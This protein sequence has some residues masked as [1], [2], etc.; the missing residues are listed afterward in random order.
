MHLY[1]WTYARYRLAAC[2]SAGCSRSAAVS[3]SNLRLEAVGYFK[4]SQPEAGAQFGAE[5]DLS[6]DGYNFVVVAPY[7]GRT[8]VGR[9][10]EQRRRIRVPARL[11]GKWFQRA[12]LDLHDHWNDADGADV[13]VATSGS[14]NTIAVALE[15]YS[16]G[17]EGGPTGQVDVYSAKPG[18][19]TYTRARIPRPAVSVFG[20]SVSLSESG[21][22]LAVGLSDEQA[23]AAIYKFV[24]GVWQNVR[25]LPGFQDGAGD[26][27]TTPVLSRDGETVAQ[28][29][30]RR[31]PRRRRQSV[32]SCGC[33]PG[34]IGRCARTSSRERGVGNSRMEP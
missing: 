15:T 17:A 1:D 20:T 30:K 21:Y 16:V 5:G 33:I 18:S 34:A 29:C 4:S 19:G 13:N 22:I 23:G 27:C 10:Y 11:D 28:L 14:G 26:F 24:N 6:P 7:E 3:V 12:R 8:E 25:N 9:F 31:T 32:L 2:N